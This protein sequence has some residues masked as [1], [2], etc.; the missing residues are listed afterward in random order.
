[1]QRQS[2]SLLRRLAAP[3]AA[4]IARA[5]TTRTFYHVARPRYT[6]SRT[7]SIAKRRSSSRH[8]LLST[9]FPL[10]A[11]YAT[12]D[13]APTLDDPAERQAMDALEE[14]TRHLEEGNVE[15]ARDHYKRSAEIQKSAAALFNLGVSPDCP[16]MIRRRVD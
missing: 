16:V 1:M 13:S 7:A 5:P 2:I 15:A 10:F 11:G 3:A 14:G 8:S 12:S 6:P 9:E 4:R